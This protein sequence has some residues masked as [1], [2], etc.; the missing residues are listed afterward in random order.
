MLGAAPGLKYKAALSVACGAG[1]RVSEV[2]ALKVSDIDSARMMIRIE[3]SKRRKDRYAML[4]PRLLELLRDWWLVCR[5]RGWLFPGR[6][7]LQ[8][9][10]DSDG[11]ETPTLSH[12]CPW[13]GGRM[14]II[15]I[16]ERGATPGH[17]PTAPINVIKIRYFMSQP[18]SASP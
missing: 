2:V 17:R 5:S 12:P 16:F 9:T 13:C 18:Q 10:D 3:Q 4:S 6:D 7:Q 8:D 1:L 15:E 14:I 11:N